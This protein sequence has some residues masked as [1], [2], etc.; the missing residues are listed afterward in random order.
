MTSTCFV[1]RAYDTKSVS[2]E[3]GALKVSNCSTENNKH[4]LSQR[5]VEPLY[6]DNSV[7]VRIDKVT[8]ICCGNQSSLVSF[9]T[10]A[11]A[12]LVLPETWKSASTSQV[13]H[14]GTS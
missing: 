3:L 9:Q 4:D 13:E 7:K 2:L 1:G 11:E 5:V 12:R 14:S 8:F 6:Q 10:H